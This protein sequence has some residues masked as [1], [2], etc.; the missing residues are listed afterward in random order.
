MIAAAQRIILLNDAPMAAELQ[1][2]AL[3]GRPAIA[4]GG[5]KEWRNQRFA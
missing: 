4:F 5:A 3:P 1:A 2:P